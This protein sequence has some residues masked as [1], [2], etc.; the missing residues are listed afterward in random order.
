VR[1]IS[2][3][4]DI[5]DKVPQSIKMYFQTVFSLGSIFEFE[6]AKETFAQSEYQQR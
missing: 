4:K 6:K 3:N 1:H 2:T 5:L